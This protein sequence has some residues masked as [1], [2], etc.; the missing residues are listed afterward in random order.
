MRIEV[1]SFKTHFSKYEAQEFKKKLAQMDD[2]FQNALYAELTLMR[3]ERDQM[4]WQVASLMQRV[5]AVQ[6]RCESLELGVVPEMEQEI[7]RCE[8]RE[9]ALTMEVG[10]A[11]EMQVPIGDSE[12][13]LRVSDLNRLKRD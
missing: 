10:R 8:E 9:R 1:D 5:T 12:L 3:E 7:R 6:A 2:T 4:A 13:M 11:K